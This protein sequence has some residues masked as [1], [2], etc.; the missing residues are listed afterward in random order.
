MFNRRKFLKNGILA[1]IGSLLFPNMVFSE[2]SDEDSILDYKPNPE[3]WD[4]LRVNIAW[5]GHSTI[6]INFYGTVILT[7]PALLDR[8]GIYIAGTSFGPSRLTP[9]ALTIDEM[10]KPDIILLSHAHMDHMDYPTLKK[11]TKKYPGQI[12]AITAYLTKD[13]IEDLQWKSL[14]VMDWNDEYEIHGIKFTAL[15]VKHFGWRF[16]WEKD[17]SRGYMED[18]RSYNAYY[19]EKS[20]TGILFGGDT[21]MTDKLD[22]IKEKNIDVALMP[23]GAYNPWK[24]AH[25]NPE[26]ALQMAESIGAKYFIPM[27]CKTFQQSQ[28]PFE[29]PID[30]VRKS[31]GN[32]KINLGLDSIGQTFTLS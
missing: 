20:G 21:T 18:G 7:D 32:Y 17:R 9:P 8:I 25:C 30:W 28:E 4:S 11:I 5:I 2:T 10:P 19:F 31:I 24:H 1:S 29:E 27:H 13:V 23:V 12:D 14:K 15:E 6:L 26:E 22:V 16:P 3:N